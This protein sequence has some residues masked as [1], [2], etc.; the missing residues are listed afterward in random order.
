MSTKPYLRGHSHQ[1]G[2][3]FA[4]GACLMLIS[5]AEDSQSQLVTIIYSLSLIFL[6]GTS[7]LY[8]R[9][10]WR[11]AARKIMKRLDHAAIYILIAGTFTPICLLAL[12][13]ESGHQLLITI[14]SVATLGVIQSLFFVDAPKWLS[15][16]IYVVAGYLILPYLS[17]LK[18]SVN[19]YLLIGGGITYTVGALTY[20]LK[21]PNFR[22]D[23]FGYHEV[24]HLLVI[25]GAMLHFILIYGLV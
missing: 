22:P 14:W 7:A 11:P 8:H 20:A 5:K 21:K 16:I 13:P 17:E 25:V 15:A 9:I 1:S 6:L 4:L 24:F 18:K 10:N 3:F 23:F 19:L 12:E 2:F